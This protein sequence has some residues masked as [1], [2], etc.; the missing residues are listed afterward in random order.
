MFILAL[1]DRSAKVALDAAGVKYRWLEQAQDFVH[2]ARQEFPAVLLVEA[3]EDD[4]AWLD[5][6]HIRQEA[7]L[8]DIP[9]LVI[10]PPS[11]RAAALEAGANE[12][13]SA[14]LEAVELGIRLES[15]R[16]LSLA[17]SL[18]VLAHDLH[19]PI[20]ITSF[21]L[22]LALEIMGSDTDMPELRQ[23]IDNVLLSN[24]RLQFMVD[25]MLDFLRLD[26]NL[27]PL[28]L[29]PVAVDQVIQKA[30]RMIQRIA[31]QNNIVVKS[32]VDPNLPMP[33]ADE[34]LLERV[35]NAGIDTAIKFSQPSSKIIVK[36]LL[37]DGKIA[38]AIN[39]TGHPIKEGYH[40]SQLFQLSLLSKAREMGSRSAVALSLPFCYMAMR[41][42][43]GDVELYSDMDSGITTLTL[44]LPV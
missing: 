35:I 31:G 11:L 28:N 21:S 2:W 3:Q 12:L 41:R 10:A 4:G 30:S 25:D 38:I 40:G 20:S 9:A 18:D 36:A 44:W 42:M 23:L 34:R 19:N 32:E 43:N 14:P 22:D 37:I 13:L 7:G 1:V 8:S 26:A 29:V 6:L 27:Y 5:A 24:Y 16:K 33:L 17:G 15:L 39:D